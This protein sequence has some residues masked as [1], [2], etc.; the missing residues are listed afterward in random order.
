MPLLQV[1]SSDDPPLFAQPLSEKKAVQQSEDT[2]RACQRCG[3][4]RKW[5]KL[6]NAVPVHDDDAALFSKLGVRL[7]LCAPEHDAS[8][9]E[10]AAVK[11][12][13][14]AKELSVTLTLSDSY[15]S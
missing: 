9:L 5:R 1:L 13:V 2:P 15:S 4:A 10:A 14:I 3:R 6:S 7:V 11:V 8:V 12:R